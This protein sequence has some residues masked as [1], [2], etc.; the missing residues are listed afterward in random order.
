MYV[1]PWKKASKFCVE[2]L[3]III[4]SVIIVFVRM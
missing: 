3:G 2:V 4:Q 1:R